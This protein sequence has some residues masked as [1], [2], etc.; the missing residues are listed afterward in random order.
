MRIDFVRTGGFAGMRLATTVDTEHLPPDQASAL[1]GL[2]SDADFFK[3]PE[4]LLPDRPAPDRFEYTV[5]VTA[6]NEIHSVVV[7][8]PMVP[9][10]LRPLLNYLTTMAMVSRKS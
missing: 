9:D 5:T 1:N 7:S 2:V 6:V 8:D 4:K 10:S 3:L